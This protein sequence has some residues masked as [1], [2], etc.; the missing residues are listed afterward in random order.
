MTTL[1]PTRTLLPLLTLVLALPALAQATAPVERPTNR[2][3]AL[4]KRSGKIIVR[5]ELDT[6]PLLGFSGTKLALTPIY[7]Y[8]PLNPKDSYKGIRA[9]VVAG[10]KDYERSTALVAREEID[11]VV[12]GLDYLIGLGAHWADE[13]GPYREAELVTQDELKIGLYHTADGNQAAFVRH[14]NDIA[15]FSLE[16]LTTLKAL[17]EDFARM[18]DEHQPTALARP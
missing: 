17:F 7:A 1:N 14:G 5:E 18:L 11:Q 9:E 2:L 16:D 15:F 4:A 3:E 13:A 8:D 6:R 12:A 10:S